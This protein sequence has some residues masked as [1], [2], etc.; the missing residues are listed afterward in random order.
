[1]LSRVADSLYWMSRYL[2]RAEHIARQLDVHLNLVLDQSI[3]AASRRRQR[4]LNCLADA[5]QHNGVDSDYDLA[6]CLTFAA[7]NQ[8]SLLFCITLA[9]E[10]A[11]QVREQISTFLW[12]Q[13]NQLYLSVRESDLG[14]IWNGRPNEFYHAINERIYL[15]QGI[16]DSRMS[17]DQS[18]HFIHLGRYLERAL[19]T[20]TLVSGE[21]AALF[22]P[23]SIGSVLDQPTYLDWVA[24]LR[25]CAASEAYGKVYRADL[26]PRLIA[27]FIVLNPVFPHSVRFACD[28]IR[29][30]LDGIAQDT[31]T[32]KGARVNRLA[33]RLCAALEY[34]QIDEV[35]E[36]GLQ[37]YLDDIQVR[38]WQIHE[39]VYQTYIFYPVEEKLAV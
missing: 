37:V 7:Q 2:E 39:A 27:E 8:S 29:M 10:N 9:R 6:E 32:H 33:G 19:N 22:Q 23:G 17:H 16:I 1:M 4:L 30:A 12:E 18:W 11:R 20:A 24:L 13:L 21:F 5:P 34:A 15:C 36:S 26:Q 14:T 3:E 31:D 35:L 28:M 38:S 25:S